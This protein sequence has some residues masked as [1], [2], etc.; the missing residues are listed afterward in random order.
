MLLRSFQIGSVPLLLLLLLCG[1]LL[2]YTSL[3]RKD[4]ESGDHRHLV[5]FAGPHKTSETSIEE[6]FH[7]YAAGRDDMPQDDALHGWIWPQVSGDNQ[8]LVKDAGIEPHQVFKHLVLNAMNQEIQEELLQIIEDEYNEKAELGIIIGSEEFDRVGRTEYTHTNAIDAVV[9]VKDRLGISDHHTTI[10]LLYKTPRIDQWLALFNFEIIEMQGGHTDAYE[11]FICDAVNTEE[12]WETLHT[13]MN[14]LHVAKA[15]RAQ[16]WDVQLIDMGGVKDAGMDVEHVIGCEILKGECDED[17]YLKE[18]RDE[19]FE[20]NSEI[21][22]SFGNRVFKAL[23]DKQEYDLENLF[24]TRD[25]NH[26]DLKDDDGITFLYEKSVLLGC[27]KLNQELVVAL[28]DEDFMLDAVRSQKDCGSE[29]MNLRDVLSG[30][31]TVAAE[32]PANQHHYDEEFEI[33]EKK[34][35][36]WYIPFILF[37]LIGLGFWYRAEIGDRI[38]RTHQ[39]GGMPFVIEATRIHQHQDRPLSVLT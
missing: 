10:V 38:D 27:D 11:E 7:T 4:D 5:V 19:T 39:Y 33:Y 31:E 9:R 26:A 25:C 23:S 30:E 37:V 14:T 34:H 3:A 18:L 29:P 15:Y 12:R 6:F 2:P 28:Q 35:H 22:D 13:A 32:D 21:Y 8:L 24:R 17:G 1:C 16:G 20:E 36:R